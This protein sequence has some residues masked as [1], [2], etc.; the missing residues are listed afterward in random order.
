M[1]PLTV[2][3]RAGRA[4][5]IRQPQPGIAGRVPANNECVQAEG[6]RERGRPGV[7]GAPDASTGALRVV[8]VD[9]PEAWRA[10]APAWNALLARSA[11]DT[12]FLTWEWL[13]T[14][15]ACFGGPDLGLF[16]L[17]V[18]D[19]RELVGVAPWCIRRRGVGPL[20]IRKVE[21]LGAPEAGS[22][23][24]DVFAAPGRER[25]VARALHD[26][27]HGEARGRWDVLHLRDVPAGSTFLVHF[28]SLLQMEGRFVEM[29]AGSVCPVVPLPAT[30]DEFT[31]T[32]SGRHRQRQARD[33][34]ILAAQGKVHLWRDLLA[35]TGEGI[36]CFLDLYRRTRP[37]PIDPRF[38]AFVE[39]A[40]AKLAA[41]GWVQVDCLSLDGRAIA[42]LLHLRYSGR[43]SMYLMAV[44]RSFST[45]VSLGSVIVGRCLEQAIQDGFHV[46]DFLKGT[47]PYKFRWA[48]SGVQ[49]FDVLVYRRHPASLALLAAC[50]VKAI[51]HALVR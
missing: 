47:E 29:R 17:T 5:G 49:C 10:L 3:T 32:R 24:L 16:I 41:R 45:K 9:S 36:G 20:R 30:T 25:E 31:S 46:Y 21:F 18:Y 22:D 8:V 43:L 26:F 1:D 37:E 15:A 14:W 51:V 44:D 27:L 4:V 33:W 7:R 48:A 40:T 28:L 35:G 39:Q 23:Y 2:L 34:R 38:L 42:G 12:V 50:Q 6:R 13:S 11:A 19:G